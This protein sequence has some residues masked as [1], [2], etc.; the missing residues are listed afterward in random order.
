MGWRMGSASPVIV[1]TCV[2]CGSN[3]DGSD[4]LSGDVVAA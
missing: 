2:T 1:S 3:V 4:D